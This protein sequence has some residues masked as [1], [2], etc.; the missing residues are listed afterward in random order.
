MLPLPPTPRFRPDL[1]RYQARPAALPKLSMLPPLLQQ[2][3]WQV[4]S[5]GVPPAHQTPRFPHLPCLREADLFTMNEF[6]MTNQCEALPYPRDPARVLSLRTRDTKRPSRKS[7]PQRYGGHQAAF[8]CT[9]STKW[10]PLWGRERRCRPHLG[11][12]WELASFS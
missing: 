9:I 3:P 2:Q 8:I 1:P 5:Q 10:F 4:S 12:T 7:L 11:L 6:L